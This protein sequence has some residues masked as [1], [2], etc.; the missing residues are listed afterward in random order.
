MS[1]M[2][3]SRNES[4][5]RQEDLIAR[6]GEL[7]KRI[8][9]HMAARLPSSV[10]VSDLIQSGVI[11]LIEAARNYSDDR[12]ASFETYASIRIRGA[13]VDELRK[14]DWAPRS[15]HRR[16]R[17]AAQ[18]IHAL[19]QTT[20]REVHDTQIAEKMGVSLTEYHQI[21]ADAARCQVLSMDARSSEEGAMDCPDQSAGPL[22]QLQKNEFHNLLAKT[23]SEMPERERMV[24]SLYYNDELNLREIGAAL[25]ISESRVCQIHGQALL[26]VK[27]R[28]EDWRKEA[29]IA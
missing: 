11:G 1:A 6:H 8:A 29:E 17:E 21:S 7:V 18:A 16:A 20:G 26:R 12:G 5:P 25:N 15:V 27:S 22:E 9:Y 28:M 10:E 19:E 14:S 13:M 3:A 4:P 24:L 23:I 2:P